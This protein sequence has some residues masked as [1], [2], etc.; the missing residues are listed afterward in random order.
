MITLI[1]PLQVRVRRM[2]RNPV[3]KSP[4]SNRPAP[5]RVGWPPLST[6]PLARRRSTDA[7]PWFPNGPHDDWKRDDQRRADWKRA[8]WQR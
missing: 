7:L 2:L 8:H 5:L 6:T 3:A 4:R 1:S